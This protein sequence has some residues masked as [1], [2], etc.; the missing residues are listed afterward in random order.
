[1]SWGELV[2]RVRDEA[3]V[4]VLWEE[5]KIPLRDELGEAGRVALVVGPEGGLEPGEAEQLGG[6]GGRLVS[7]GPR[8]LRTEVA[9]VV[10]ASAVLFRY[11]VIG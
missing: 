7:L 9:P 8:I 1:M 5:A 11:G 2:A 4:L 6:A 3:L 10:A